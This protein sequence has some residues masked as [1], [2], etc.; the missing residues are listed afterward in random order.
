MSLFDNDTDPNDAGYSDKQSV[1][2]TV[3]TTSVTL[4]NDSATA[5]EV[6]GE[7]LLASTAAE[8]DAD[9]IRML[10]GSCP[11]HQQLMPHIPC[12]R[13]GD[14]IHQA[15]FQRKSLVYDAQ[16]HYPGCLGCYG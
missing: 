4:S 6:F 11:P 5:G 7:P 14:Q 10:N 15:I 3:E 1:T 12:R 13:H 16:R 9:K 8:D 2:L